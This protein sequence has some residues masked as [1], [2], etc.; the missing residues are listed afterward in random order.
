MGTRDFGGVAFLWL[1]APG[2]WAYEPA[3]LSAVPNFQLFGSLSR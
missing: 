1:P 2:V 3:N